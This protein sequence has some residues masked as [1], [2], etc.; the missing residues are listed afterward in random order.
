MSSGANIKKMKAGFVG[1]FVEMCGT[2]EPA[3]IQRSLNLP[4]QTVRNYLLG[5]LPNADM[6]MHIAERTSCSIDWLLTGRGKKFISE[7]P[8]IDTPLATGQME[9]FVRRICVEVINELS[10]RQVPA[11]GKIVVLQSSDLL[12]EKVP[13]EVPS[14]TGRER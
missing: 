6:L 4:Y 9:T 2:D 8:A 3:E 11:A 13:D 10:G 7:A 14:L 5:R 1:R 12:S